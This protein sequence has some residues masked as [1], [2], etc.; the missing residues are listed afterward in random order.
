MTELLSKWLAH[1]D[2][3][4]RG[5]TPAGIANGVCATGGW[6][7]PRITGGY[8]LRRACSRLPAA[9]DPIVGAAGSEAA[10]IRT[11]PWVRHA[12]NS[13]YEYA[14]TA[15]SGGGVENWVEAARCEVGFDSAGQWLGPRPN[16]PRDLRIAPAAGGKLVLRW[17]YC[18]AGQAIAPVEFRVYTDRGGGELDYSSPEASVAYRPGRMHFNFT[19]GEFGEGTRT[20]WAVRAASSA[21]VEDGG[22]CVV[23]ALADAAGPVGGAVVVTEIV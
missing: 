4:H 2:P 19:T 5:W 15:I 1:Y 20:R 10:D 9:A 17:M 21:G 12:A 11:F 6:S 8:N 13:G 7:F 3:I 14:L 22:E 23:G 16:A 18:E